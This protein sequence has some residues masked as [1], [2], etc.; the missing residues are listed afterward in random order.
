MN[1]LD[2]SHEPPHIM[3]IDAL[4]GEHG[5]IRGV[6]NMDAT[7]IRVNTIRVYSME[8]RQAANDACTDRR[9]Q[10]RDQRQGREDYSVCQHE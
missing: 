7:K 5:V 6:I 1:A 4:E 2:K 8:R 9:C 3:E 10:G